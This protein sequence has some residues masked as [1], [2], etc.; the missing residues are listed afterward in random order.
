[1]IARLLR[2]TAPPILAAWLASACLPW[3]AVIGAETGTSVGA[4]NG[5]IL[6]GAAE[7][8]GDGEHY[9]S[10]RRPEMRFGVKELVGLVER[11]ASKVAAA[12]PGAILYVGEMSAASGGAAQGHASHRTGRDVDFSFYV[13][14]P[15]GRGLTGYPVTRFDRFGAG[16]AG[17]RGDALRFDARRNWA[18]VEALLADEEAEVQWIFAS[19][20]VKALLLRWA[21]DHDRDPEVISR[22]IDVL[23][24]P[25]DSAPHDDHFH[26]RIYCPA[27]AG[28]GCVDVGPV[29]PWVRGRAV[30][31]AAQAISDA[32]LAALAL[33]GL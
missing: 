1:V 27:S 10:Y 26:V 30:E 33:E 2:S 24:Q 15:S 12:H 31:P 18:L 22:A 25:G 7:L 9:H 32:D 19:D 5:G 4:I 20:G 21:L 13:A 8:P 3:S 14:D 6:L 29:W 17:D 23:R 28:A 16:T 11:A